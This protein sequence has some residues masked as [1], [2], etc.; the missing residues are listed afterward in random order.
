[1]QRLDRLEGRESE[2]QLPADLR[3]FLST[4]WFSSDRKDS[5][6]DIV[7]V[8]ENSLGATSQLILGEKEENHG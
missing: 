1:M 5:T 7:R 4:I 3:E 2:E 6:E 8:A